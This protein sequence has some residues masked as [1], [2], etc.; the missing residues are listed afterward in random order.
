MKLAKLALA[1]LGIVSVL[2]G[3]AP[4]ARAGGG[5]EGDCTIT[6][7]TVNLNNK[8]T[9][10]G[11]GVIEMFDFNPANGQVTGA[12][13]TLTLS[14]KTM[15]GIFRAHLGPTAFP[16]P[17]SAGCQVL[18]A[19]PTDANGATIQQAFGLAPGAELKLCFVTDPKKPDR[20]LCQSISFENSGVPGTTNYTAAMNKLV[21]YIFTQ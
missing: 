6:D 19:A 11:S 21:I 10:V 1:V 7:S 15:T 18:A 14:Y 12:D 20:A 8:P 17:E 3:F 16:T 9:I 13:A 2:F 4:D 5:G